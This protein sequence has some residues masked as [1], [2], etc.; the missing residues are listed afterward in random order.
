MVGDFEFKPLEF[1]V[2]K[3]RVGGARLQARAI[4]WLDQATQLLLLFFRLAPQLIDLV[5]QI[6]NVEGVVNL[7][8]HILHLVELLLAPGLRFPV[9]G[10]PLV[11]V[12]K[13]A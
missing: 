10:D 13:A 5:L 4:R 1:R 8:Q 12:R 9:L 7:Q 3:L 11:Q 6:E 2:V